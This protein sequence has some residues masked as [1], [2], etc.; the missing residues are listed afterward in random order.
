MIKVPIRF[1]C[2]IEKNPI[3]EHYKNSGQL[4]LLR[5]KKLIV[6]RD[7]FLYILCVVSVDAVFSKNAG[8][9]CPYCGRYF[10][11]NSDNHV[12][13]EYGLREVM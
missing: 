10:K 11:R 12:V 8:W 3:N 1:M 4:D 6:N 9:L 2:K 13:L 7:G 5:K